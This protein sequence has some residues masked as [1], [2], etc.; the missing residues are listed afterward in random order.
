[1]NDN[2][3]DIK[4]GSDHGRVHR[5]ANGVPFC[6]GQGSVDLNVYVGLKGTSVA[7]CARLVDALHSR[8]TGGDGGH[9]GGL[10]TD[11]RIRQLLQ[12]RLGKLP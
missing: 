9:G 8:N 2:I 6:D 4:T 5:M 10:R 1:M 7:A 3:I 12:R 11:L